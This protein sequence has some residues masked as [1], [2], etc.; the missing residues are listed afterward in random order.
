MKLH[1]IFKAILLISALNSLTLAN[2]HHKWSTT[3]SKTAELKISRISQSVGT[4]HRVA[5][6]C[7]YT[8]ECSMIVSTG[9]FTTI[10]FAV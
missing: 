7:F 3:I 9:S 10:S 1:E 6:D 5:A 8:V 2:L 4:F